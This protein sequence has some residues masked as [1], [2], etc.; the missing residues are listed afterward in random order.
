MTITPFV[1]PPLSALAEYPSVGDSIEF[2]LSGLV[3]VFVALS[4]IWGVMEL[5]GLYFRR[6]KAPAPRPAAAV[7]AAAPAPAVQ[8]AGLDPDI[9]AVIAAAAAC[10]TF[11]GNFR[12]CS[13]TPVTGSLDWAR[14]GRREI[15][16][17]HR[18]R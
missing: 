9:V 3:V 1:R 8:P 16:A 12:I 13:I 18:T 7:V 4:S 10:S 17:S 2:Q 6:R 5:M 15:F 14:E 11:G